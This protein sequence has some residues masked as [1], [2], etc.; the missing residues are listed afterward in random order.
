[1]SY[2]GVFRPIALLIVTAVTWLAVACE[3]EGPPNPY[4]TA[5]HGPYGNLGSM[6]IEYS[7][8]DWD[9]FFSDWKPVRKA[10]WTPDGSQI[11]FGFK[12]RVFAVDNKGNNLRDLYAS[13]NTDTYGGNFWNYDHAPALSPDGTR[14]AITTLRHGLFLDENGVEEYTRQREIAVSDPDGSNYQRLTYDRNQDMHPAWSPDGT[15]IAYISGPRSD[16]DPFGDG[17]SEV[18]GVPAVEERDAIMLIDMDGQSP[19]I[20]LTGSEVHA[21]RHPLAWSPD[22]RYIA[23]YGATH[24]DKTVALYTIH[25]EDGEIY[26]IADGLVWFQWSTATGR[27]IYFP[28]DEHFTYQER[29]ADGGEAN[30]VIARGKLRTATPDGSDVRFMDPPF[31]GWYNRVESIWWSPDGTEIRLFGTQVVAKP[32]TSGELGTS[33]TEVLTTTGLFR[34][35][36]QSGQLMETI[37]FD[38]TETVVVGYRVDHTWPVMPWPVISWSSD[39]SRIAV[40]TATRLGFEGTVL[41]TLDAALQN[42][43]KLVT[44]FIDGTD[45]CALLAFRLVGADGQEVRR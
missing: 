27:I 45:G 13:Y 22:G 18:Y 35:N 34:G 28:I 30:K 43:R 9:G 26:K 5:C 20:P 8:S 38:W 3:Y 10:I 4:N 16:V 1:M 40:T 21:F 15:H 33:G 24:D 17:D 32:L 39:G 42:K 44:S 41:Y 11:I 31:D 14:L 37:G 7:V 23:F 6:P 12:D 25:M 36:S 29:R 2:S 19:P